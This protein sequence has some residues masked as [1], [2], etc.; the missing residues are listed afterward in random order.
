MPF[1]KKGEID[2]SLKTLALILKESQRLTWLNKFNYWLNFAKYLDNQ[3]ISFTIF[4]KWLNYGRKANLSKFGKSF[5]GQ[6]SLVKFGKSTK[7]DWRF[8]SHYF[9]EVAVQMYWI[10]CQWYWISTKSEVAKFTSNGY[11]PLLLHDLGYLKRALKQLK[12]CRKRAH[13]CKSSLNWK[14]PWTLSCNLIFLSCIA[15][16]VFGRDIRVEGSTLPS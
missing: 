5:N 13:T 2:N 7:S 11:L 10:R 4:V 15:Q 16:V 1:I 14:S 3:N 12:R 6:E 8:S 9:Q